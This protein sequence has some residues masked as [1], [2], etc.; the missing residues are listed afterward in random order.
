M[1]VLWILNTVWNQKYLTWRN[2]RKTKNGSQKPPFEW[3]TRAS[4]LC[5][6]AANLER[7]IAF[8]APLRKMVALTMERTVLY[9]FHMWK[10]SIWIEE[11][12]ENGTQFLNNFSSTEFVSPIQS[13]R[14]KRQLPYLFDKTK[15]PHRETHEQKWLWE[16]KIVYILEEWTSNCSFIFY[17]KNQFLL[18]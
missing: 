14:V 11:I 9:A 18:L 5:A 13:F 1:H 7:F 12:L 8:L 17:F 10:Q 3:Q 16:L 15:Y 2:W 4:Y 6:F